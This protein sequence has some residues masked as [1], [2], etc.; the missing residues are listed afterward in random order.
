MRDLQY[1]KLAPRDGHLAS[2][3]LYC[4]G[5]NSRC[6]AFNHHFV[7][8]NRCF[9][10]FKYLTSFDLQL[11]LHCVQSLLC[12]VQISHFVRSSI[13]TAWRSKIPT[14]DGVQ[15]VTHFLNTAQQCLN[16]ERS[17]AI[18]RH[19]VPIEY[20]FQRLTAFNQHFVLFKFGC[21]ES[22]NTA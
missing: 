6:A 19:N 13:A 9:A 5:F 20:I 16:A 8:F 22:L 11:P 7:V 14:H 15:L 17:E 10:A 21:L 12:S 3:N 1:L 18:E 2:F 4:M